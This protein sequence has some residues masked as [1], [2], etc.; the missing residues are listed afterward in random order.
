M[1]NAAPTTF[2][3]VNGSMLFLS[4]AQCTDQQAI[5]P[6]TDLRTLLRRIRR[7]RNRHNVRHAQRTIVREGGER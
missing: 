5:N 3:R 4:C 6:N 7:F 1:H 2:A